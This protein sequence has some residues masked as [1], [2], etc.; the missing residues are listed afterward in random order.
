MLFSVLG[1]GSRGNSLFVESGDTALIIDNGFSGKELESRLNSIG[2]SLSSIDG[3][4]VTHEHND[5]VSGVGVVS[6]RYK[7][8]VYGNSGTLAASEQ[9]MGKLHRR[10]EFDTGDR[11]AIRD[12]EIVSFPVSHDTVDPVGYVISDGSRYLGYC[13]DTGTTTRLMEVRLARCH[14]LVLEFNHNLEMLRKGPYPIPLQQRVRSTLG[15]LANEDAADF[16]T[17]LMHPQLKYG[18]LAHLS[19]TNNTPELAYTAACP[20]FHE[21]EAELVMSRQEGPTALLAL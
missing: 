8:P 15:H 10:I 14:G 19:E 11:L 5:H 3:V 9:K 4:C 6:R 1:S 18:V 16:L 12:L 21:Q 2:R 20:C 17:R 7:V 13:T